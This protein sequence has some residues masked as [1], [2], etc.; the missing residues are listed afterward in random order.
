MPDYA[1]KASASLRKDAIHP[2]AQKSGV[3]WHGF[4]NWTKLTRSKNES[5]EGR[6]D[7]SPALSLSN[8]SIGNLQIS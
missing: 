3:F 2:Q 8:P 7:N 1:G 4:I 6:V 5:L